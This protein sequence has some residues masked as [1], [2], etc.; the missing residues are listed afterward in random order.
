MSCVC[1]GLLLIYMIILSENV[2]FILLHITQG[3]RTC[4]PTSVIQNNEIGGGVSWNS[5]VT[6][7]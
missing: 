2:I 5:G 4:S 7:G 3:A 6:A 1:V